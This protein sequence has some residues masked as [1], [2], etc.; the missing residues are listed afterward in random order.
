[1]MW[2]DAAPASASLTLRFHFK[3]DFTKFMK[4]LFFNVPFLP[5]LD[6]DPD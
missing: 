1:M 4:S 3:F 5:G 2:L 6:P